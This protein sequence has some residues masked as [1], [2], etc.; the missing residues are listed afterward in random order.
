MSYVWKEKNTKNTFLVPICLQLN[1]EPWFTEFSA[2][3][4]SWDRIMCIW[5]IFIKKWWNHIIWVFFCVLDLQWWI[6]NWEN[7]TL[8]KTIIIVKQH[9]LLQLRCQSPHEV[10]HSY[11][12]KLTSLCTCAVE[13]ATFIFS[14][15]WE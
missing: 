13:G 4:V 12:E 11:P 3:E 1:R 9:V 15:I 8:N 2:P 5:Q 14:A 7:A 10:L 6:V